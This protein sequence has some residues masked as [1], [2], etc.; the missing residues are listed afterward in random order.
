M[1]T[2]AQFETLLALTREI[3]MTL[4]A[5]QRNNEAPAV[6]DA[7]HRISHEHEAIRRDLREIL[8]L[9][10]QSQSAASD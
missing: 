9:L 4:D 8:L 10:A 1:P 5:H 7:L 2:E 6:N 3:K